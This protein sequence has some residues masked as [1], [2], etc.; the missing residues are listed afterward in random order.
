MCWC[1]QGAA[2]R[3]AEGGG[4]RGRVHHRPGGGGAAEPGVCV[5]LR[6]T[7]VRQ[8]G[9][10]GAVLGLPGEGGPGGRQGGEDDRHPDG[11]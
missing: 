11:R 5:R 2:L 10:E 3:P 6:A 1:G 7:G 9:Q 8:P 4:R